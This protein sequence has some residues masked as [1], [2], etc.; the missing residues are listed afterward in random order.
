MNDDIFSLYEYNRWA[1]VLMLEACKKL[2]PDQFGA[3]PVPGWSSVRLTLVHIAIVT[4]GWLRGLTGEN[5]TTAPTEAELS[6]VA[7]SE[8][9]L[10]MA[11]ATL[12]KLKPGMTPEWL[13]KPFHLHGRGR[14]ILLPPWVILRH[15]VNHA[16]Y[17]RGQIASKLKRFG[18]EAPATDLIYWAMEQMQKVSKV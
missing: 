16:T 3:E 13:A 1:N 6:T 10:E 14:S 4:D 9:L 18:V 5:V 7:D 15:I 8:R 2:T 11:Y 17:H 12:A